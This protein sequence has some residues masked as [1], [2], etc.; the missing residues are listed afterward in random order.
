[1]LTPRKNESKG[2]VESAAP[3]VKPGKRVA[4]AKPDAVAV[5][6]T[7]SK[8][9]SAKPLKAKAAAAPQ[10]AQQETTSDDIAKLAYLLWEARSITA[11][12]GTPEEDWLRAEALL[13]A[14]STTV[15]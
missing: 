13:R 7:T 8:T 10:I 9:S 5:K 4:A 12:G 1:M 2:A 3:P 6:K 15:S 11:R 14:G